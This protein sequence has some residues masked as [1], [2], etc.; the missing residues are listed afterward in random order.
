MP[1]VADELPDHI[2][3]ADGHEFVPSLIAA[4]PWD[5]GA[6]HGGPPTALFG[7]LLRDHDPGGVE[8]FL[9]RI[10]VELERPVPMT[11]LTV[12]VEVTR[13]G[14]RVQVL[15]AEMLADGQRVARARGVRIARTDAGPPDDADLPMPPSLEAPRPASVPKLRLAE[16][17][18]VTF[19]D[20][21]DIRPVT[22]MPFLELGPAR[23]WFRL[24]VPLLAGEEI[25]PLDRVL[26]MSDFP[27]GVS[28]V[29]PFE[30][31]VYINPDLTVHLHRLPGQEW[32]LLDAATWVR[33]AGHGQAV[34]GIHDDDGRLGTA[35]QSLMIWRR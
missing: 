8:W 5:P 1:D 9:A 25:D 20:A 16:V 12:R 10:T 21:V 3:T 23:V 31:F 29:V 32:L 18:H 34:A 19:A 26:T 24:E 27:N 13:P 7:R 35:L 4:G 6:Q 28:N 17:G 33:H 14:R 30:E 22:G 2:Y 11:P 15:D